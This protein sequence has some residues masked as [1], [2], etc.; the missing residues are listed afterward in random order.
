[1][2]IKD[3]WYIVCP[4]IQLHDSEPKAAQVGAD[5]YVAF[6]DD[7][8]KPCVLLDR[9]CHRG[10]KLSLGRMQN[11]CIACGYHGWQYNG[12]GKLTFVPSLG[13][14]STVP[15]YSV[16]SYH[17]AEKY[18]Y[19]WM[20]IA[21]TSVEPDHEPVLRGVTS[22]NWIQQTVLWSTNV[23][24]AVENQLDVA[25][26]AFAHPGIYPTHDTKPG[27]IP[28]LTKA[29]YVC[30]VD[31]KSVLLAWKSA[32][33]EIPEPLPHPEQPGA[34]FALFELPY[35]NYVFLEN[36]SVRAIYNWVP[37]SHNTCRV[38]FLS[39]SAD[40]GELSI[41]FLEGE[42]EL[43]SQDRILLESAQAWFDKGTDNYEKNV[44]PD[45][46]PLAARQLVRDLLDG[47]TSQLK[48]RR[49]TYSAYT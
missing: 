23:M 46:A 1:V 18:Q 28:N 7:K 32:N 25:H 17:V 26:T 8:G 29:E 34:G 45:G 36:E 43:L 21:G 20:W 30:D 11:G 44:R 22:G 27:E 12:G 5:S 33:G 42:L 3:Q 4:S 31:D 48:K 13:P 49:I 38:E 6:R 35:R 24:P 40:G 14:T 47:S 15:N 39:R 37:L 10:V 19:V 9:C 2:L 16:P 41:S